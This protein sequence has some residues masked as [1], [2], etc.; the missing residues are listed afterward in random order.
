MIYVVTLNPS[1]D[2]LM[3][4][5][6]FE[7]GVTNRSSHESTFIGGKSV[8]VSIMLNNLEVDSTLIGF[9]AGFT[10]DYIQKELETYP[11]IKTDFTKV[12]GITRINVKLKGVEET[13]INGV[14]SEIKNEN[15]DQLEAKI[16]KLKTSDIVV[17][18]GSVA[19]G[20]D[21]KWYLK[22]AKHLHNHQIPFIVDISNDIMLDI[23]E[24][25]PLLIKPNKSELEQ[26]FNTDSLDES[27]LINYGK[28]LIERGAQHCIVSIG[29]EGSLFF[30]EDLVMKSGVPKGNLISSVGAG[31]SMVAGFLSSW[32]NDKDSK[33]AY[34]LAVSAGSATAYSNHLAHKDLVDELLNDVNVEIIKEDT[35]L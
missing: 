23:L 35:K 3:E 2:Y 15:L 12:S 18:T 11:R 4:L 31:D 7:L 8:N 14:G 6:S 32:I 24:Y 28:S 34:E 22:I 13:E 16:T 29:S 21:Y 25:K 10:G 20:M 27:E 19:K 33:K 17:L 1:I 5:D 9:V 30:S 26:I